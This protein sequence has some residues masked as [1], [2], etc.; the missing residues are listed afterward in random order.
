MFSTIWNN[1]IYFPVL[2]LLIVFYDLLF[3]NLGLAIIVI[4]ILIRLILIPLMKRQ[5]EMTKKMSS[6]KPQIDALQKKYKNNPEKLSEEQIKLYKKVGYNPLGCLITFVPQLLILSVLIQVIRNVATGDLNGIYL[7][8]TNLLNDG[9]SLTINTRFLIWDLTKSFNDLSSEFGKFSVE[10]LPYLGLSV[11]VGISQ[12]LTTKFT[13]VMQGGLPQPEE[14]KKGKE[15]SP[16]E[17]TKKMTKSFSLILPFTTIF[18]AI[19]APAA[20]SL[21]WAI[22][23]FTL[24]IQYMLLDW[25]KTEKGIQ[26][27]FTKLR[28]NKEKSK[29]SPK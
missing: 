29:K 3:E 27:L 8:V 9:A 20:L 22:Q 5:T 21:Y 11:L 4:A 16:E 1:V 2:N 26:N 7:F 13:Q 12:Y 23:S 6:L 14:P 15:L 28:K 19:S 24:V 18:I 10:A 17:M 25:D